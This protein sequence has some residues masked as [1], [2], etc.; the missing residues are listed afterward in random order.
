MKRILSKFNL[1]FLLIIL[2]N[3]SSAENIFVYDKSEILIE[4]QEP[5]P[6]EKAERFGEIYATEIIL[7]IVGLFLIQSLF[8][9]KHIEPDD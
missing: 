9:K 8:S 2:L 7:T 1:L 5:T 4:C 6:T 3:T